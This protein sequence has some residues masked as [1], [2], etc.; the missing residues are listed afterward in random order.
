MRHYVYKITN[1]INNKYYFGKHST[2]DI[3]DD[4][5]GSGMAMMRAHKKY[6]IENFKKEIIKEFDT[7]EDALEYEASIV[8]ESVVADKNSYNLTVGGKGSWFHCNTKEFR[9]KNPSKLLGRKLSEE[10]K[11]KISLGGVGRKVSDEEREN[12]SLR[13]SGDKNGM[14]GKK[15]KQETIEKM[16]IKSTGKKLSDEAKQKISKAHKGKIVSDELREYFSSIY[17]GRKDSD[18]TR[19]RKSESGKLKVMSSEHRENLSKAL[20]GRKFS[21]EHRKKISEGLT[22]KDGKRHKNYMIICDEAKKVITDNPTMS[23]AKI[24]KKLEEIGIYIKCGRITRYRNMNK[25]R[26]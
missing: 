20:K 1:V 22:L 8:T 17:K 9:D 19:R 26:K 15:H 6:G 10:H 23:V 13:V 7:E 18:E 2:N 12:M 5:Y 21:D 11:K 4:Y 24:S 16:R 25:L 14:Y 3:N